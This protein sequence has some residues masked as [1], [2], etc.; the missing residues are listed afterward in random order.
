MLAKPDD[1]TAQ[2]LK[3]LRTDG[4]FQRITAWLQASL[5]ALDEKN[6]LTT[7]GVQ[8]RMQQGAAAA[9]SEAV[10]YFTGKTEGATALAHIPARAAPGQ[11]IP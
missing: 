6:R 8:L 10:R 3:R 7:D 2:A 5:A 4:D 1:M 9:T 11:R